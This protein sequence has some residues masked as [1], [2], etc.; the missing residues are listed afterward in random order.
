MRAG[1]RV[2]LWWEAEDR[3]ELLASLLRTVQTVWEADGERR[4]CLERSARLY[5]PGLGLGRWSGEAGRYGAL[6][7]NV[8]RSLCQTAS[9]KLLETAPPRAQYVT[10]EADWDTMRR[11]KGTTRLAAAVLYR[12]AFD[13]QARGDTLL[14]AALGTAVSKILEGPDGEPTVERV[15]PWELLVDPKDGFDGK[16][17]S[18]YQ[19]AP[20]DRERLRSRF[21]FASNDDEGDDDEER[22]EVR[23]AIDAAGQAGLD[24]EE[25]VDSVLDEVVLLEAWH[26]PSSEG[27]GD[28]RHVIFTDAG[29]LVDEPWEEPSFPFA[30]FR[31]T[32]PLTGFWSP[33][34][35]DEI[36]TLQYEINLVL[37]RIRQ[38]LHTVAVPRVWLEEGSAV[39]PGPLSNEIGARH[40]Y[41]GAKPI[42]ET[43]RAVA[44]E[45]WQYLEYLW[46]KAF[47][48]LGISELAAS[49]MKPAGIDSG[50]ALRIYAD[51]TSGRLR[52]WALA[53]QDYYLQVSQQLVALMRRSSKR[54][55][56]EIVYLDRE[57]R[58]LRKVRVADVALKEGTYAVQCLPV[59]SLPSTPSARLQVLE[60]WLNAGLIDVTTYKRLLDVPDLGAETALELAPRE[61][62]EA[63]VWA[64]LYGSDDEAE[65]A[66]KPGKY[67]DPAIWLRYGPRHILRAQMAGC[68]VERIVLLEEHLAEAQ[69]LQ[70][71]IAA[72][73]AAQQ[74]AAT[75]GA[76][77]GAPGG[78]GVAPPEMAA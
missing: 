67:D 30:F 19:I 76:G 56:S 75:A 25:M 12:A 39:S 49:S 64:V 68:P 9:A 57:W 34:I 27:A 5:G 17:R 23:R 50:R 51:L 73:L 1:D 2:P 21:G 31:W 7:L 32:R 36:W 54:G 20:I 59:S 70:E 41:R 26:L 72:E 55:R 24:A 62:F 44:P 10:D 77:A 16:P 28:G 42:F 3:E 65:E 78:P 33:G 6:S 43:A 71:E 69:A 63:T 14:S 47:A 29:V 35:G 58:R 45:L 13:E 52:G 61:A 53:W 22:S 38:M 46:S 11:A 48:L 40:Y 4:R 66:R 37:E 60:E 8:V 18:L 74:T 15:F